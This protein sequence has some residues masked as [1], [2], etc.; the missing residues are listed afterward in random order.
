MTNIDIYLEDTTIGSTIN[1]DKAP[2][3]PSNFIYFQQGI[4][5]FV[6]LRVRQDICD[7]TG[8]EDC[9]L[10]HIQFCTVLT[11]CKVSRI[12]QER[13]YCLT[14]AV[15]QN[16]GFLLWKNSLAEKVNFFYL[17]LVIFHDICYSN[18]DNFMLMSK[19]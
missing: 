11:F 16:V 15:F 3:L 13:A 14:Q 12:F 10:Q 7:S 5:H 6:G 9:R 4:S 19:I 8:T 1:H 18:I 2:A 17:K